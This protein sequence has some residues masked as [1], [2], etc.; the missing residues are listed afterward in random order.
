MKDSSHI[1]RERQT[2]EEGKEEGNT[3]PDT[4]KGKERATVPARQGSTRSGVGRAEALA[5][6]WIVQIRCL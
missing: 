3:D 4:E 5:D 6:W 2:R 1:T